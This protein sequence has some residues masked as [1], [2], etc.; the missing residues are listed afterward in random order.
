[1]KQNYK[2]MMKL[3]V[4]L[5]L[6]FSDISVL[7][8]DDILRIGIFPRRSVAVTTKMFTPL[9]EY[10]A[11]QLD[12][13]VSIDVPPDMPAFW[14]RLENG[15]YDLVHLNQYHYVRANAKSGWQA[16]LK[17]EEFGEGNI[18]GALWVLKESDI[19]RIDDLR[20]KLIVFGGGDHAMVA[21]IM[22]RDLLQQAG[23]SG[24]S[25][26]GMATL[27]PL[28]SI[29][30]VY[31]KQADAAGVA[32][33]VVKFPII[34]KKIDISKLRLLAKSK[35]LAHLPWAIRGDMEVNE[36]DKIKNSLLSLNDSSNGKS[37]LESAG[38]TGI[39]PVLDRDY[40]E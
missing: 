28:K 6:F 31:Y 13:K 37:V 4:I 27:Q 36:K 23:L 3:I 25:Y 29:I 11:E 7:L 18:A 9:A 33:L 14:S 30:S 17:N 35:S 15:D 21:S 10:L 32:D 38:M 20:G 40:D 12:R 22:T 24:D 39:R 1:M 5:S 16:I 19:K 26:I 8:A 34:R 2:N